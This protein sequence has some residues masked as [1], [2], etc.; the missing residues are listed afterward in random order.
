MTEKDDPA[1]TAPNGRDGR[2]HEERVEA[3][4]DDDSA[5]RWRLLALFL[6]GVL[7][8][9]IWELL[10]FRLY[11]HE[12]G[13]SVLW[14]H[15]LLAAG[16]DGALVVLLYAIGLGRTRDDIWYLHPRAREVA[17]VSAIAAA[18]GIASELIG[19]YGVR[20]WT[21]AD[22]MPLV[23]VLKIGLVPV[24]STLIVPL[25]AFVVTGFVFDRARGRS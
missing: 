19:V 21:Y 18:L 17:L 16:G 15:S 22:A 11:V 8:G 24:I 12:G 23:P 3:K 13:E 1:N 20:R 6:S 4:P 5:A 2:R 25:V 7:I 9:A 10:Q 14:S